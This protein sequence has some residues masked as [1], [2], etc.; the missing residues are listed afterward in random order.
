MDERTICQK[1]VMGVELHIYSVEQVEAVELIKETKEQGNCDIQGS[2][3][4][5]T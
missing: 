5:I 4:Q 3:T 2:Q 1:K